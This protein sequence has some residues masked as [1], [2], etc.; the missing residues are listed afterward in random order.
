VWSAVTAGLSA[1]AAPCANIAISGTR[2]TPQ[3]SDEL[4]DDGTAL[5]GG[6]ALSSCSGK[7]RARLDGTRLRINEFTLYGAGSAA[8]F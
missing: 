4:A 8:A 3:L 2:G 5:R 6:T 1:C 7:L